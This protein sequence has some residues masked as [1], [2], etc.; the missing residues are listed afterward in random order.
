MNKSYH[1]ARSAGASRAEAARA[2]LRDLASALLYN[3]APED[4]E[5]VR[6]RLLSLGDLLVALESEEDK[7]C[8]TSRKG[9]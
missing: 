7:V 3:P 6:A 5:E 4:L 8:R 1:T 2:E 9:L